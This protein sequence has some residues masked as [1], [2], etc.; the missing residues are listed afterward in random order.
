LAVL[1]ASDA[2]PTGDAGGDANMSKPMAKTRGLQLSDYTLPIFCDPKAQR[3]E[4][5]KITRIG[6]KYIGREAAEVRDLQLIL[7]D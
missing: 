3:S 5:Y 2:T 6:K 1:E 7:R 4:P